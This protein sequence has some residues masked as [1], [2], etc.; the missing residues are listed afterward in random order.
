MR[1]RK[2]GK[3]SE[4]LTSAVCARGGGDDGVALEPPRGGRRGLAEAERL[5]RGGVGADVDVQAAVGRLDR[6]A[7]VE[8]LARGGGAENDEGGCS[9]CVSPIM[10]FFL[11][12]SRSGRTRGV[13]G[14]LCLP[15]LPLLLSFSSPGDTPALL[16]KAGLCA[17]RAW[18]VLALRYSLSLYLC[19]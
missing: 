9:A 16:K 13:Q 11:L 14:N 7:D 1:G 12:L 2:E 4:T 6:A 17:R 5:V 8:E 3:G 15:P 19:R 18:S 10:I